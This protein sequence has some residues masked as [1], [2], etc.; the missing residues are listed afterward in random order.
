MVYAENLSQPSIFD[1]ARSGDFKAISY[2]INSYLGPQGIY[3]HVGF[4]RRG[5]L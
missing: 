2:L 4:Q 1:L 5:R 3:A